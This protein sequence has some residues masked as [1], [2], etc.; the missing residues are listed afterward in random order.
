MSFSLTFAEL[1]T[2]AIPQSG[3]VN[4]K[5]LHLLLQG[6][7]EHIHIGD[8][9]KVLSGDEDFLQTSPVVVM[10]REGD[11]QPILSPMKRLSNV[12]DHVMN[13]IDK[14]E[15]QLAI[16]QDLPSTTQLLECSQGTI[17]PIQDLWHLIK[18]RKMVEGNEEAMAK[19]IQTLQDLLTDFYALKATVEDLRKDVDMLKDMF[20][21]VHPERL[22]LFSEDLNTQNRQM[23]VLKRE[24]MSL[25]KKV[26][27]IPSSDDVVLWTGLHEAMFTP[28]AA[29][30][31][32]ELSTMWPTTEPRPQVAIA[33]TQTLEEVGHTHVAGPIQGP[34]LLQAAWQSDIQPSTSPLG[35]LQSSQLQPSTAPP[36]A[37]VSQD[38]VPKDGVPRD[39]APEVRPKG[40]K[41]APHRLRT[42][43]AT[44]AA[45]AAAYAAAAASATQTARAAAKM[46][47]DVPATKLATEATTTAA[48]GPLG[49]FAD[50]MGAG[51]FRGALDS[52]T[53][54]TDGEK[55]EDLLPGY[56]TVSSPS[57]LG[58][59]IHESALSQ[60]MLAATQ[61]ICLEDKKK[62]VKYSMSH[63]AQMPIKHDTLKEEFAQLS[64]DLQQRLNYLADIGG[65]SRL[66]MA[67]DLL[68]ERLNSLQKSRLKEEELERVWSTQLEAMKNHYIV[69]DRAMEKIQIRLDDFKILQAQVKSLEQ[70]KVNK[71]TM[72]QELKE[73]ADRSALASKASRADL[74]TVVMELNSM[75]QGMLLK[76]STHEDD[77][78]KSVKQLRKDMDTK[79]VSSDLDALKKEVAEVWQAVRKLMIEGFR[80]DPDR[81]AGFRRQLFEQV[82]CISCDRN[83][84][85]MTAPQLITI[86]R[87]HLLSRLRPASAN[88]YEYLQ[89]QQMREHHQLQFQDLSI[90]KESFDP[91]G[92]HQDWGDGPRNDPSLKL[93]SY[94]LSTLYPYGNPQ[95][96]DYDTAEVDILGVDGILYKG[97]MNNQTGTRLLATVE[98]EPAAPGAI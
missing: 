92:S 37:M 35:P 84:E 75:I 17:R 96:I 50:V 69:L 7:L 56:E 54:G 59:N 16:L 79:L 67:V 87:A 15:N 36:P 97:R 82:K 11:A 63:I 91:L 43:F 49:V 5:A 21:K 89:R 27:T 10:P 12:F 93:K 44:A 94:N 22:E 78:N 80:L 13:R 25:Q 85:I 76:V 20:E 51:V 9:K 64:S 86:R 57:T 42:T 66:G 8:L 53:F 38:R 24:M 2:V 19:S 4:F 58:L 74:E 68:E 23:I 73:K 95:V 31:E 98:K 30:L 45:A 47:E 26:H 48:S 52:T 55:Q 32:P 41:S 83:V 40:P 14:I 65:A 39:R 90:P 18:L 72:E 77:W 71:S 33:Q 60:S 81:V 6:I 34:R 1:A 62:A 29:A 88:S 70:S 46:I 3:T 61:A 28:G